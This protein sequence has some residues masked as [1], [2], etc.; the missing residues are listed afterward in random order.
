MAFTKI[1]TPQKI[2]ILSGKCTI[3][4]IN[5]GE[6]LKNGTL[7]CNSCSCNKS[8]EEEENDDN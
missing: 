3:C 4:G 2:T 5:K 8:N 7:I 6:I 1:G